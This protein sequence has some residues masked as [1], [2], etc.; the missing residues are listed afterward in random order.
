M[1]MAGLL[2]PAAAPI[3]TYFR[4]LGV[5]DEPVT[6]E[7]A[8]EWLEAILTAKR[9]PD[10][11]LDEM[12]IILEDAHRGT[13][14]RV[15]EGLVFKDKGQQIGKLLRTE[16]GRDFVAGLQS[17]EE[18]IVTMVK[19]AASRGKE[20]ALK[21][22]KEYSMLDLR[23]DGGLTA[24]MLSAKGS[25][26]SAVRTL[27]GAGANLDMKDDEGHRALWY[28]SGASKDELIRLGAEE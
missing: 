11:L 12:A 6:A 4:T 13:L 8:T 22:L 18:S 26:I 23:V 20:H 14:L 15:L 3:V 25:D 19:A 16:A 5:P 7:M 9:A 24:L 21:A 17:E 28:A 10:G 2:E 27:A 1:A